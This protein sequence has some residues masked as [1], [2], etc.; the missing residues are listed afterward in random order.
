MMLLM[1]C[2]FCAGHECSCDSKAPTPPPP[3]SLETSALPTTP[4]QLSFGPGAHSATPVHDP[5]ARVVVD[6]SSNDQCASFPVARTEP[7]H[8]THS[9]DGGDTREAQLVCGAEGGPESPMSD[10]EVTAGLWCKMGLSRADEQ[11]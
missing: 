7:S 3:V 6:A 1:L 9:V 11:L 4:G 5:H 10:H 2:A 8:I